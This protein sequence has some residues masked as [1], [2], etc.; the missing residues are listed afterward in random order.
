MIAALKYLEQ[1]GYGEDFELVV[2][3]AEASELGMDVNVPIH[4]V[5]Y[6]G[7]TQEL[8]SLYNLADV[9]VVPS[10]TENLSCAIMESLSCGTPVVAFDI[11]GNG[12]MIEHQRNGYLAKEKDDAD[13][14]Q[15]ILWCLGH[16]QDNR[17]GLSAREKVLREYTFEAVCKKYMELYEEVNNK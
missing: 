12:D 10:L 3:G 6:V 13:L 9:M 7:N 14:A 4:Y 11:G 1:Q 17:L 8:A 2:F 16:N 15:G 5:G